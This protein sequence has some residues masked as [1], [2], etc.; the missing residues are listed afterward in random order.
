MEALFK[1]YF[2]VIKTLGIATA[3]GLAASAV[4]TQLGA[5]VL[6]ESSDDDGE[7][8]DGDTDGDED[9]DDEDGDAKAKR[10][11]FSF[12]ESAL[13]GSNPKAQA[14]DRVGEQIRKHNIFCPSCAPEVPETP[15]AGGLD[16]AGRPTG[17]LIQPGETRSRLPLRLM[18]TMEAL[19]PEASF[20]TILD[21]EAGVAGLF[22]RGDLVRKGVVVMGVD[23]GLVHLRN[24]AALEYIELGG[25]AP[26]PVARR[27]SPLPPRRRPPLPRRAARPPVGCLAIMALHTKILLGL[28]VGGLL[29]IV[30]NATLGGDHSLVVWI[31]DYPAKLLGQVFLRML[32]MVVMPLVFASIALG[33]TGIGDVRRVGRVGGKTLAY[34]LVTTVL[35][36]A[37]GLAL[38]YPVEPG[39]RIPDAVQQ[40]LMATYAGDASAKVEAAGRVEFGID[41]FIAI[42]TRNPIASAADGDLLGLIFFALMF[43]AALTLIDKERARPMIAVLEALSDVVTTIIDLAMKLAP[44]GVAGLIFGV[45][46]RFG[47]ELLQP[48]AIYVGLVLGALFLHVAIT[49]SLIVRFGIGMSPLRFFSLVRA[50]LITAFST[51]SSAATLPTN[52]AV[53]TERLGVPSRVAGFVLPLGATMCMNGTS[54]FEGITVI[55]LCQVFDVSLTMSS[56]LIIMTMSVITAVG[57]AAVPGGSLPLMVG[58]LAMFGVP[59]EAIAIVLG[60]DR[61]LDMARTT[62]NVVGDLT[63]AAFIARSEGAWEPSMAEGG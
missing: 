11:G 60:I 24:N 4:T 13:V 16:E 30:A 33:V 17:P 35:S 25:D 26:P 59:G 20:A 62:V 40:Q 58:I 29:G 47:T 48:L 32:F 23:Q 10:R 19:D 39:T 45:T 50:S 57:A 34:F 31:N 55:F 56:M 5:R 41:T 46:S 9:E 6:F 1:K 49:M 44:Y 43:G 14:K 61:V 12:D 8:T 21:T 2:W 36:T 3:C 42:V 53:A 63:A 18:A 27:P 15:E 54:L 37:L 52:L 28:L 38:V 51:S 22:G 7:D